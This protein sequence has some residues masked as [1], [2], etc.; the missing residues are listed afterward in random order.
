MRGSR[1]GHRARARAHAARGASGGGRGRSAPLG[2]PR[3]TRADATRSITT[4]CIPARRTVSLFTS[5]TRPASFPVPTCKRAPRQRRKYKSNRIKHHRQQ[6]HGGCGGLRAGGRAGD[7]AHVGAVFEGIE[8]RRTPRGR[9]LVG[10]REVA[11]ECGAEEGQG[12]PHMMHVRRAAP[13]RRDRRWLQQDLRAA[14][15]RAAPSET[16]VMTPAS[17]I[18]MGCRIARSVRAGGGAVGGGGRPL[19]CWRAR[20]RARGAASARGGGAAGRGG[21]GRCAALR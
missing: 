3:G 15:P 4:V 13:V 19:G 21:R 2:S 12:A 1:G 20:G 9:E 8:Q 18:R 10:R 7:L 16:R 6:P 5:A 11:G 14:P 17:S